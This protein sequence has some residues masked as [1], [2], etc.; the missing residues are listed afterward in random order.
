MIGEGLAAY[1]F[2]VV[3]IR[4]RDRDTP[5][6][7]EAA[8][9]AKIATIGMLCGGFTESSLRQGGCIEI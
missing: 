4:R 2:G 1:N 6:D 8:V 3:V 5:Y 9:K 7:A